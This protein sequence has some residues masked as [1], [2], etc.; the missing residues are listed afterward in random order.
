MMIGYVCF[1]GAWSNGSMDECTR[2]HSRMALKMGSFFSDYYADFSYFPFL[3]IFQLLFPL[4][5]WR[6]CCA[7]QK[8]EQ[9]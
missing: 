6:L 1:L 2:G 7:E 3:E 5:I 4:Q 9:L 8:P